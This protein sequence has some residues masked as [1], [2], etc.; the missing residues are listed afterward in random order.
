MKDSVKYVIQRVIFIFLT[1]FIILSLTYI[2]L[3]LIPVTPGG[4]DIQKWTYWERQVELGYYV[5]ITDVS[6]QQSADEVV[7]VNGAY[8]YYKAQ[9][10]MVRYLN[11]LLGV[12]KG[13]WASPLATTGRGRTLC[14]SS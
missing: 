12:L 13:Q 5:R 10:I 14:R 4:T 8:Y 9:P 3:Q 6:A 11:W 2:L 1:A 7:S